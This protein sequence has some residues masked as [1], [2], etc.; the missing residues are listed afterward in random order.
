ML[1]IHAPSASSTSQQSNQTPNLLPARISHDGPIEAAERYWKVETDANGTKIAHFRGRKMTAKPLR[2]P[3][4]YTGAILQFTDRVDETP[5]ADTEI[6]EDDDEGDE[7]QE[8]LV[9]T[10]IVET[11]GQ[12]DEIMV[13]QQGGEAEE[14]QDPYARGITEW[15]GFAEAMHGEPDETGKSEGADSKPV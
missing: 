10:K 12:F 15:I 8:E 9:Q 5:A 3:D 2:L 4:N 14:T 7:E 13:W 1:Q 11:V 6:Q